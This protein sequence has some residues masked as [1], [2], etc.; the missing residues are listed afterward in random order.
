MCIRDSLNRLGI[1]I[2]DNAKLK[3]HSENKICQL[4]VFIQ[5]DSF[6]EALF[7][8]MAKWLRKL[9]AN[10]LYSNGMVSNP[11]FDMTLFGC[12]VKW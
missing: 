7:D 4:K 3:Y 8:K 10:S 11:V 1:N 9:Y 6:F 2:H 5:T 12:M